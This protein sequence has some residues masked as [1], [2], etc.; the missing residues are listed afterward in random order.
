VPEFAAN[1]GAIVAVNGQVWGEEDPLRTTGVP[2]T[3][4]F[5]NNV[6][7]TSNTTNKNEILMGFTR[8]GS[9][10]IQANLIPHHLNDNSQFNDLANIKYRYQMYGSNSGVIENGICQTDVTVSAWS[11][12]G[13]SDTA[14]VFLSTATG[15]QYLQQDF[16]TTLQ[17]FNV[18]Q[19]IRQDG[20]TAA[21][22]Y[23]GGSVGKLVNPLQGADRLRLGEARHVAYALGV[24]A[25]APPPPPPP[26]DLHCPTDGLYCGNDGVGG[27]PNVLYQCTGGVAMISQVCPQGCQTNP[28]GQNDQ[29]AGLHC[30][31]DGLYCGTDG[32]GG[33]QD[34][35]YQCTGGVAVAVQ[36]CPNGCQTN[37]PGQNDQCASN[38]LNCPTNGFYCGS[39]GVG[40]DPNTLYQCT[41]GV[42]DIAAIC[43]NGCQ[44]NP[45][46]QNDQCIGWHCP[47]DGLY[48]GSDGVGGDAKTLYQCIGGVA[49]VAQVCPNGCQTN[50]PGQ[51]DRCG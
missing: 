4:T 51:N 13:F 42:A 43:P 29:C 44:T 46:G 45:P 34:T 27:D 2:S 10:G 23:V 30:P 15:S 1:F 22:L 35:L 47:T 32:V 37:P 8:G 21:G 41:G 33:D 31:T 38:G 6:Q 7:K 3:T 17:N 36:K 19:A 11:V 12:V 50:P 18:T 26:P 25:I 49:T 16:C 5:V 20:A 9:A 28:P 14:I 39:D 24:V 40:G 48:C